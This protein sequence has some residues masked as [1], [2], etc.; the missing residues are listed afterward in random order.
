MKT[1]PQV[2]DVADIEVENFCHI[3]SFQ[4]SANLAFSL[5]TRVN[6]NLSRVDVTGV[7]ELLR[8]LVRTGELEV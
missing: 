2:N 4:M 3:D 8:L 1:I 5:I 6:E 7:L